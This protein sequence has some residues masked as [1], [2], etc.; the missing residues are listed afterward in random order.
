MA[1]DLMQCEE[2][3]D[4]PPAGRRERQAAPRQDESNGNRSNDQVLEEPVS[5]VVWRPGERN[6]FDGERCTQR[7]RKPAR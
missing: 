2:E 4:E 1:P 5:S 7:D 3:E 6:E